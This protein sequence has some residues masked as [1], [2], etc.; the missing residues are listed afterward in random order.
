MSRIASL[1][2][3]LAIAANAQGQ[4]EPLVKKV[5]TSIHQ[6]VTFLTDKQA[7]DG[8]WDPVKGD[9]KDANH[10]GTTALA[11]LALLQCDEIPDDPQLEQKRKRSIE[12]GLENLRKIESPRVYV[13]ALQTMALAEAGAL[14]K[15]RGLIEKNVQWLVEA[16]VRV[17]GKF[18]GWEYDKKPG[19]HSADA[20]NSQYAMLALW[21]ARQAGVKIDREVWV[22]I[23][24]YYT[25]TQSKDGSWMYSPY[26]G[27]A[28]RERPSLTM[29]VAGV[30]GL[31]IASMELNG[32]REQWQPDGK[33]KNCG[34]YGD[35]RPLALAL[36]WLG[37]TFDV[38]PDGRAYYH[39]YGL[40]RA[41]RLTGQRFF[42]EHDWYREGCEFLVQHQE[43]DGSWK[44][45]DG[46]DRWPHVN[47]AFA[48]L[49]LSKG[50]TPVLISKLVHGE[51]KKGRNEQDLDWNN[52]RNDL[53]HLTEYVAKTDMFGK[54]PL[55]WQTYDIARAR[56]A[57]INTYK[58]T[59]A[60]V[61]AAIVADMKQSPILYITGHKHFKSRF[62]DNETTLIKRY[63]ENGGFIFA[64]ACC[65]EKEFDDGFK[66]WVKETWDQDLK[67]LKTE[68]PIWTCENIVKAGEPYKLMGLEIGCRTVMLY[69]PQD[70]SCHWESNR[71]DDAKAQ[72][73]FR[74]GA[75]I[76]A[77]GT[78]RTPPLPRL[79]Q[80]EIG[81][82]DN[83]M[84]EPRGRGVFHVAQIQ[85]SRDGPPAPR[86]MSNLLEHVHKNTGL[87][88]SLKTEKIQFSSA[89]RAIRREKFFYLHGRNEFAVK[90]DD[91]APLQF[92]LQHGGLLFADACCGNEAFDKSFRKLVQDLFP[93]E[94]FVRVP[95]EDKDRDP[96]FGAKN[97]GGDVLTATNIQCRTKANGKMQP[98]EPMLEGIKIDGR[99]VVLYS[100]YD[101]G[102]ALERHTSPDC[103]GYAPDSA[104]RLATAVVRYHALP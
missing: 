90:A 92:T 99:W 66:E 104:L 81:G 60:E 34:N 94:K 79:T 2:I 85:L 95:F 55:A 47:T 102:C 69:S 29:T 83:K 103:V 41:G 39:L 58:A 43:I 9:E 62:T 17:A 63:I 46:W 15:D 101:I 51:W 14:K 11:L 64:E 5:K 13:R 53:R 36:H 78:G 40:E 82:S 54:K 61:D 10:G 18:I 50:R 6:G 20:S 28:N 72:A 91:L 24:D 56:E 8:S 16:R 76:I 38:K 100:R 26:Y 45:R 37:K 59:G 75:N 68:H 73:A 71:L 52:D 80:F 42:G 84:K 35:D 57:H 93:K 27:P 89:E 32:G 30:C 7:A 70:L 23:R 44:N 31:Q 12:R 98:M 49:F 21:Y 87:D 97:N 33:F 74:L 22:G 67:Y 48:L 1:L 77:Y 88:V 86:A 96:L 65:G 3:I 4:Q 19:N 25:D